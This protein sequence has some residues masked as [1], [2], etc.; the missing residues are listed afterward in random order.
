[1]VESLCCTYE[2]ITTLLTSYAMLCAKS[3]QSSLTLC[4]PMVYS[5]PGSAVHG[6]LQARILKWLAIPFSSGPHFVKILHHDPSD[7]GGPTRN[8]S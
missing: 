4:D 7:L 6:I 5:Q 8:G 3:L 1:M 2:T